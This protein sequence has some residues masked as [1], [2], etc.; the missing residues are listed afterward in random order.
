MHLFLAAMHLAAS[1]FLL[2]VVMPLLLVAMHLAA[3]S[4][5]LLVV[6]PLLLVAMH[7]LHSSR[8]RSVFRLRGSQKMPLPSGFLD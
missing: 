1:S 3:S 4:F 8:F 5:L 7:L 6:V 2:L